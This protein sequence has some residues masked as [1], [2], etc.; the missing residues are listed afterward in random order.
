MSDQHFDV[1]IPARY[2][3]SRFPGK[4]LVLINGVPLI[5]RVLSRAENFFDRNRLFVATDN[6]EIYKLVKSAGHKAVMT[7]AE[8][9]T[10]TDRVAEAARI[11][12]SSAVLNIQ[13]D[14]PLLTSRHFQVIVEAAKANPE[15]A[16]NCYAPVRNEE[17]FRSRNVPKVVLSENGNLMYASRLAIP[18][19]K[20]SKHA[21]LGFK[22]V[23]VYYFPAE[24]LHHFGLGVAKSNHESVEDIEILRLVERSV[25]V[26]M[27]LLEGEF[28]AVDVPEDVEVVERMLELEG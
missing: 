2:A 15:V 4:P 9:A 18:G 12:G 27:H 25:P 3:S 22:Q 11:L 20:D 13:G 16:H 1:I 24:A 7:P 6:E 19:F 26:S 17:E 23:C 21:K 14:E 28:Q 5:L 8:C 10:G